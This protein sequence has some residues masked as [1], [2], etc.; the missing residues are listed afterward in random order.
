MSSRHVRF[1]KRPASPILGRA[2]A[3]H[4]VKHIG[5]AINEEGKTELTIL[6]RERQS[7]TARRVEDWNDQWKTGMIRS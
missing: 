1:A 3:P 2:V 7:E 6:I 4:C 5:V